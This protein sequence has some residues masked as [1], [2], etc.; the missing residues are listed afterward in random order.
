MVTV[1]EYLERLF[2]TGVRTADLPELRPVHQH[3]IWQRM[4]PGDGPDR[5]ATVIE[6]LR[7]Q[8]HRFHV[9]GGSWTNDI[10]WVRGYDNVLAPMERASSLFHDRVLARGV[11]TDDPGY[12]AALFHLLSAETSCYRYWGQG[13]WTE[14]G[15]E[16]SRRAIE[17]VE[18]IG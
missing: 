16:L 12:R 1:S 7:G 11:R 5:L 2:A 18:R 14:Y 10:S 3:Q 4:A 9:D 17:N 15:E 8:D 13:I 6:E